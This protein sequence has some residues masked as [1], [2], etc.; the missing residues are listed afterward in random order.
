VSIEVELNGKGGRVCKQAQ[1]G[2][3]HC[4]LI[5]RPSSE[6]LVVGNVFGLLKHIRPH[7]W[8]GPMLNLALETNRFRQVWYKRLSIR[9]WERQAKF[10]P[11][12]LDFREGHTET[13]LVIEWENPP[14]TVWIEAKW[15]SRMATRTVNCAT[16]DQVIRGVRTLLAETGH[17]RPPR[18]FDKPV[19]QPIWVA[20]VPS[21]PEP[22]VERYRNSQAIFGEQ[23]PAAPASLPVQSFVG[24]TTWADLRRIA[25]QFSGL[26][27]TAERSIATQMRDYLDSRLQCPTSRLVSESSETLDPCKT[28]IGC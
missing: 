27:T 7:L 14:T 11:E 22:K 4:G 2:E 13:D 3:I 20:L 19:R 15:A 21:K 16:N 17:I 1:A 9:F 26:M 25:R 12:L 28:L 5:V 6:D 10:P 24:T 23:R 18:L 8:L